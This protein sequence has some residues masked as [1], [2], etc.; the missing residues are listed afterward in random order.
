MGT[1]AQTHFTIECNTNKTAHTVK[2][3]LAA[4]KE[5]EHQNTFAEDVSI[6]ENEVTGFMSSGRYQNLEYKCEHIWKTIKD[7]KGV[8]NANFPMLAETDGIYFSN[9]KDEKEN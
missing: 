8:I 3:A 6:E 5:D 9:D 7:T 1:Y 4:M 2:K